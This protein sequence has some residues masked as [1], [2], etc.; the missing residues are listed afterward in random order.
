MAPRRI[1]AVV[2]FGTTSALTGF[3]E[4]ADSVDSAEAAGETSEN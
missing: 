4:R 3:G 2:A 1:P